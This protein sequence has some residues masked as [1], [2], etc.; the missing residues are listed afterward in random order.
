[1][2]RPNETRPWTVPQTLRAVLFDLDGTL[3]DTAADIASAL[4]HA[5]APRGAFTTDQVR[6]MIGRGVPTLIERA[7]QRLNVAAGEPERAAIQQRFY[8]HYQ[9][10]HDGDEFLTRPYPGAAQALGALFARGMKIAVVTNKPRDA[11]VAVL[12]RL[13]L[14]NWIH[15]VVGG[16]SCAQRKPHPRPL[17]LALE[18]LGVRATQALMVGDSQIDVETAR[19]AGVPILCVPYGYNEGADPRTLPCDGFV[20]SLGEL[21]GLLTA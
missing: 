14:H 9:Q 20:E 18:R 17:L 3:L 2:S 12:A 11:A 5:L 16:D 10:L 21:P 1:V 7:L 8:T 15:V 6:Q 4:N 13:G 19:A